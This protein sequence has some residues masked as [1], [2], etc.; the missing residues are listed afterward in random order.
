MLLTIEQAAKAVLA[1]KARLPMRVGICILAVEILR[2]GW[3]LVKEVGMS[4]DSD[5]AY[6]NCR[7]LV[8]FMPRS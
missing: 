3:N 8:Q 5:E 4:A 6:L 1:V 7:S 2:S